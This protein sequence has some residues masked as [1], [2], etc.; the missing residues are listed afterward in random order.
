MEND[1]VAIV[2]TCQAG[3]QV[4]CSLRG[5]GYVE[6]IILLGA[7]AYA[8]YQRPPLLKSFLNCLVAVDSVNSPADHMAARKLI[9]QPVRISANALA[10][11]Q[12][13]L[14]SFL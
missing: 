12:Q 6:P 8:P 2:G 13:P 14:K 4:A 7:K 11:P 9:A 3:Y 5:G 10:D 1:G